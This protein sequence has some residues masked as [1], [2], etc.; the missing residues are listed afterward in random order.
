MEWLQQMYWL[1]I[2]SKLE[3]QRF[4]LPD[5]Q[6]KYNEMFFPIKQ[7]M[8]SVR[9]KVLGIVAEDCVFQFKNALINNRS[10]T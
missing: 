7:A 10:L 5:F 2:K 9:W 1:T 4:E 3:V 6:L 8:M